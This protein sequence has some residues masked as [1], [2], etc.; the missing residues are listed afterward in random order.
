MILVMDCHGHESFGEC[1]VVGIACAWMM[2]RG[3]FRLGLF[4]RLGLKLAL[5]L[6]RCGEFE[7]LF[8]GLNHPRPLGGMILVAK[9][10]MS[11]VSRGVSVL[12]LLAASQ[13]ACQVQHL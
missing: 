1:F 4:V 11:I 8:G 7:H 2:T 12:D 5:V 9:L 3:S 10:K 13:V 6:G